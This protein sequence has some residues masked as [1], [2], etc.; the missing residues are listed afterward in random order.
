MDSWHYSFYD[1]GKIGI[2]NHLNRNL[3]KNIRIA[4]KS[5]VTYQE[6]Y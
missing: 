2:F 6:V 3:H 1:A 5:V 4:P